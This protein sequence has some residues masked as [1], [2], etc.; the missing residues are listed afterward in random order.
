MKFVKFY[1]IASADNAIL[2][3]IIRNLYSR[4]QIYIEWPVHC[5]EGGA[6]FPSLLRRGIMYCFRGAR[7]RIPAGS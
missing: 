5:I 6:K 3:S 2:G 7:A 1:D 4:R